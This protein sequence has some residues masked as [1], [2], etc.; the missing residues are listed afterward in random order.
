[1]PR[2]AYE[3]LNIGIQRRFRNMGFS[4]KENFGLDTETYKGYVKLICDNDGRYSF[5]DEFQDIIEFLLN[6]KYRNAFNWFYNINF[7]FQSIVKHLPLDELAY[8]YRNKNLNIDGLNLQYLDKKFFA[9]T[10]DKRNCYYFYDLYNFLDTSLDKASKKFLGDEKLKIID[11][12]RLNTDAGCWNK[13]S[14]DIIRYCI[15]DAQLTKRLADHFWNIVYENLH[16]YPKRPFSKG[17]LSEEYFLSKCYIP[18]INNIPAKVIEYAYE[19]YYGGRFELL[20]KGFFEQIY[21]YDIKSAYPAQIAGLIDFSLGEWKKTKAL[22]EDLEY[23]FFK[24][25]VDSLEVFFS[26]FRKKIGA[27]NIYPNGKFTQYLSKQEIDFINENY[28]HTEIKIID[29]Y[30]FIPKSFVYPFREEVKKLYSWKEKEKDPDIKYCV[31]IILNSLYGKTIQVS[32]DDN[33]TGKL[34]NPLYASLI[35]SGVRIKLLQTALAEPDSIVSF[36]TDSITSTE[37]IEVPS[38]PG[39]GDFAFDFEGSGVFIMSDIYNLWN[40]KTHDVKSRLRGFAFRKEKDYDDN[41]VL[42]KDILKNMH[43]ST[44]YKYVTSRPYHLGECL[45]HTKIKNVSMI[46]VF[47]DVEKTIDINGDNKRL[48]DNQFKSGQDAM[49]RNIQSIPL[50]V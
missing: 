21:C 7:D 23:G 25:K 42:L 28:E 17:K 18:T 38:S 46:N 19:S 29:G 39:L 30:E 20:Q 15:K 3:L 12:N 1:M 31:K 50:E 22:N 36:S 40:T 2:I 9:I 49:K 44:E 37:K 10:D 8:L 33:R 14:D 26:P 32:G 6:K 27:L 16:Y 4:K 43:D 48:W 41:I 34:F 13:N 5:V 11:A 24:C 35:T 45:L 47:Y